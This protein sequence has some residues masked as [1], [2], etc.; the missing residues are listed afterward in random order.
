MLR[1]RRAAAKSR[2]LTPRVDRLEARQLL[3]TVPSP[4]TGHVARPMFVVG[5]QV[6]NSSPSPGAM[7]PTQ[8]RQA[9]G[10]DKISF[11]AVKGDGTGQT[12]A[13]VDAMDDPNIQADLDTFSAQFGLPRTTVARVD[14]TGGTAYPAADT[15][16]GWETEMALDVEWAHAIAPA[17]SILLV[18]AKT[19]S[20][21]DL[22][23]GVD[24][25]A[26][27]AGVVSMSWGG[28]EFSGE[29]NAS[30]ELHFQHA[31]VTF[32]ASSGDNG[33]PASWPAVSPNVVAVGGTALTLGANNAYASESGWGGSGGGP[34]TY[35][36]KP[37][38]QAG[39]VTQTTARAN[40][41]VAYNASPSTGFAVY[42]SF[43]QNG[44]MTVGGTS[45]GAPQWAALLAIVDQ[46]RAQTAQPP[47]NN[48]SPQEVLTTL[49]RSTS[50][51]DFRDVTTGTSAGNPNYGAT[52]GYDFVTGLGSPKADLIA[53]TFVG[54][55]APPA[56]N[57]TLAITA[58]ATDTAG[59]AYS[60]TVTARNS[61]GGVDTGYLGT[62]RLTSSDGQAGLPASYTFTAADA[63]SHTFTVT[64]KTAGTQ[65]VS[66]TDTATAAVSGT[67]SGVAVSAAAASQL[68]L[69][70]LAST[71]AAGSTQTFTV[72]AKD[73]YGNVATGY[74]GT[75]HVAS[76]DALAAVPA[77]Y[78][79]TAADKG[80]HGFSV[81]FK[82]AG[83]QSVT[84]SDTASGLSATQTGVSVSPA[85][86]I[87]LTATAAST[88]QVNLSWSGSA[89][90][91]SYLIERRLNSGTTWGQVGSTA[92]AATTYQDS[93]LTPGTAYVYRVRATGGGANSAYS[94]TASVTTAAPASSAP[95]SLW[96]NSYTPSEDSYGSGSYELGMK[97]RT[98]K[99]GTVSAVRFYKQTWMDGY[100]HVGHLWSSSGVLLATATFTGESYYGWQ[101]VSFSSP[102]A[103]AANT[104]YV[105]SFSTGG[106]YFGVSNNALTNGVDNGP[107]HALSNATAG[108]NG[109][110]R[111]G[112]GLFPNVSGSGM[113]F[114]VDLAFAPS[115]SPAA[116]ASPAPAV[117]R[118]A[119]AST[120]TA[121]VAAPAA[122][123]E[124]TTAQ[125]GSRREPA[126]VVSAVRPFR[127]AVPQSW[128]PST[129]RA[130][131]SWNFAPSG[132]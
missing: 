113:N 79:F 62:V 46:G 6:T 28:G 85:A 78:A 13:I 119:P 99:A 47:L 55:V 2:P 59:A 43:T 106:G 40:P 61:A 108:G 115:V 16:G 68:L 72:T 92:G 90:A 86:P 93:G 39:V 11:G 125:V 82:T 58:A 114:W 24:Y 7:T 41:D 117:A 67:L 22:L 71:A 128:T 80:A 105:V 37:A 9:Y 15:T 42:D 23:A 103:V 91:T 5:P 60:V 3:S 36:A 88:S 18:E 34:S 25:A 48:T 30:V 77:D 89:G 124:S 123:T 54:T 132:S 1:T 129:S 69:S 97:F 32:V 65:S 127:R 76:S 63:G 29:Q 66:A 52:A 116:Q 12:V 44:W 35:E 109:V 21:T 101:Q 64:L 110:Y 56:A 121:P 130:R 33:A 122:V 104:T 27:H 75:V 83:T 70:G 53:Q 17:A 100:A 8:V 95:I 111:S 45:A 96:A 20:D 19:A 50:T 57:D 74:T 10:F 87:S 73:A 126:V 81:T 38:Y 118:P 4:L 31:G 51:A 112:T 84:V 14:Q 131:G 49:Y 120:V 98:D 107:L 94:N 102:V 26:A